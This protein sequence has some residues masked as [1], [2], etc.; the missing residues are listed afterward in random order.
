MSKDTE[1]GGIATR[2][3]TPV[4]IITVLESPYYSCFGIS[5]ALR[6]H[7]T[8]RTHF[9]TQSLCR[10]KKAGSSTDLHRDVET[11][12][13]CTDDLLR[14]KFRL[15]QTDARRLARVALDMVSSFLSGCFN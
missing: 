8:K 14:A 13:I 2:N 5:V 15:G 1:G 11:R 6:G 7:R 3:S 9:A 10:R 12:S 4:S